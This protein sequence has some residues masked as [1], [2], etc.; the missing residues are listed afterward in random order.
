MESVKDTL[1]AILIGGVLI[2]LWHSGAMAAI[3]E[4]WLKP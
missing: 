1:W 3:L 4:M 2:F